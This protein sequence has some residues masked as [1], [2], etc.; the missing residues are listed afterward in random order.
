MSARGRPGS[1]SLPAA[2]L[3]HRSRA[4]E[5]APRM[6]LPGRAGPRAPRAAPAPGP[7]EE[8]PA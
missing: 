3:A 7:R 1:R 4:G 6:S 5:E 8:A 2:L